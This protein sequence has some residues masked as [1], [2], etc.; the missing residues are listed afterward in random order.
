LIS[1][2]DETG[3]QT[4]SF[5]DGLGS[6]LRTVKGSDGTTVSTYRFDVFGEMRSPPAGMP[7]DTMLFTGEQ[8][9]AKA[10]RRTGGVPLSAGIVWSESGSGLGR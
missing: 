10:P 8:Y 7:K 5:T 6:T 1:R 3:A 4:Y 9:K 2:T